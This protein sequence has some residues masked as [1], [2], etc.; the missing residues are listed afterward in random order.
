MS[1][2]RWG[3]CVCVYVHVCVMEGGYEYFVHIYIHTNIFE[4]NGSIQ[5]PL[6]PQ[7]YYQN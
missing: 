3:W 4:S 5:F 6:Y 2:T 1:Y 7:N